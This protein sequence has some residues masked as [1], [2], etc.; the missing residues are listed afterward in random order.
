MSRRAS[1]SDQ[2]RLDRRVYTAFTEAELE[3]IDEW[4]FARRIRER[5]QVIRRLT[6]SGL[7]AES[8]E[9]AA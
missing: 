1:E 2:E 8:K 7:E 3:Q 4:G 6:L 5:S 9:T